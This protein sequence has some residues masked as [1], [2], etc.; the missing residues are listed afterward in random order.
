MTE[1]QARHFVEKAS[2]YSGTQADIWTIGDTPEP[3]GIGQII[4]RLLEI[5]GWK[6]ASWNL[7]RRRGS[8]GGSGCCK[9]RF[10]FG[11]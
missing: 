6:T 8:H 1:V 11:Y 4:F 9:G 2:K 5:S 7:D 3:T 10:W